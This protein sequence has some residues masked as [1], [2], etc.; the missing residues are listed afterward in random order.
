MNFIQGMVQMNALAVTSFRMFQAECAEPD[1]ICAVF[2]AYIRQ[3][4]VSPVDV[5]LYG[6]SSR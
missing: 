1:I 4:T 3:H 6:T 2:D 5:E